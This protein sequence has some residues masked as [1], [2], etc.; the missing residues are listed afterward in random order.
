MTNPEQCFAVLKDWLVFAVTQSLVTVIKCGFFAAWVI[1]VWLLHEYVIKEFIV[2]EWVPWILVRV[3][4]TL[5]DLS[6]L[7]TTVLFLFGTH[8]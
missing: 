1:S 3:F 2:E 6:T 7:K 4:E 5:F 8:K